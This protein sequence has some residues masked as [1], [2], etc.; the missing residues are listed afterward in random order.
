MASISL[1]PTRGPEIS[2]EVS[3]LQMLEDKTSETVQAMLESISKDIPICTQEAET[4]L[5]YVKTTFNPAR[6]ALSTAVRKLAV[7]KDSHL[8]IA[9]YMVCYCMIDFTKSK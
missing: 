6:K 8:L 2:D 1:H 5:S 3:T 9:R 7:E 4:I